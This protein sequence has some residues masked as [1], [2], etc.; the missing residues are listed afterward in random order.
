MRGVVSVGSGARGGRNV[1]AKVREDKKVAPGK[2]NAACDYG[3]LVV[4]NKTM[5]LLRV[6][7]AVVTFFTEEKDGDEAY[8]SVGDVKRV[9]EGENTRGGFEFDEAHADGADR[10]VAKAFDRVAF[11]R[12]DGLKVR[13]DGR[14][15]ARGTSVNDEW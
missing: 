3:V 13:K 7:M 9:F 12:A 5:F 2:Y 8:R 11:Y 4:R 15:V 6:K 10:L 1:Y 14:N